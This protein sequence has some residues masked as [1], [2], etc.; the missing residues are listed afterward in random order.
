MVGAAAAAERLKIK[1][2][3]FLVLHT[4]SRPRARETQ[5]YDEMAEVPEEN[6]DKDHF[7]KRV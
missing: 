6:T 7:A 2:D 5:R 3:L 1:L 4:E